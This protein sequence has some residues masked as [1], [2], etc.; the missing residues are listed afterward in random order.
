MLSDVFFFFFWKIRAFGLRP[1]GDSDIT[2]CFE[3]IYFDVV[4][5]SGYPF[6]LFLHHY[7]FF[8]EPKSS[9]FRWKNPSK[10]LL[11]HNLCITLCRFDT[12]WKQLYVHVIKIAIVEANRACQFQ[13]LGV[14]L[15]FLYVVQTYYNRVEAEE[16]SPKTIL[17]QGAMFRTQDYLQLE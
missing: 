8:Q 12:L 2:P 5:L 14:A 1:K 6:L 13:F 16:E 10:D 9:D 7:Y 4:C 17:S 11:V 15:E 3:L